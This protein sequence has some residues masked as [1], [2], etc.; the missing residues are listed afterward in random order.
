MANRVFCPAIADNRTSANLA[1]QAFVVNKQFL[2]PV[3][4]RE[5]QSH[6]SVMGGHLREQAHSHSV[7]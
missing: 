1:D 3:E 6:E 4:A 5:G 7:Q 2:R